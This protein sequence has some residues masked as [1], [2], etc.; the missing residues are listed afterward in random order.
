MSMEVLENLSQIKKS[1]AELKRLGVSQ[2]V[3]PVARFF[4]R[5]RSSDFVSVGDQI[6]S[7]DVLRTFQFL[8]EFASKEAAILDIGCYA[9]EI[10]MA[11]H[12]SGY[13][14]LVGAD[15]SPDIKHLPHQD[16][17]S[18]EVTDFMNTPFPDES[19]SAITSISVIEHGFNQA[20]LLREMSRLLAPGGY[21]I[22]SFDYWPDKIDTTG[23]KFFNIEW[24]IFSKSEIDA[25]VTAAASYNLFPVGDM[26]HAA[27]ER[28]I[29]CGGKEYTFGW[30]VLRKKQPT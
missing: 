27:V 14:R 26:K 5:L 18:F 8:E 2:V 16:E 10:L 22:A 6:K 17:I 7:W 25:F 15:L 28:P 20:R 9:S 30:M 1:R 29:K 19:F 21:F 4:N 3:P 23:V 11:L 13:T 24:T 12:Q